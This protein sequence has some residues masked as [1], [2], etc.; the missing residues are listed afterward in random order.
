MIRWPDGSPPPTRQAVLGSP[1]TAWAPRSSGRSGPPSLVTS[2]VPPTCSTTVRSSSST[3]SNGF[4]AEVVAGRVRGGLTRPLGVPS[5]VP[6]R[7][8]PG[9][10]P[11]PVR[12]G[13]DE[14]GV[15][16]PAR[17]TSCSSSRAADWS[18]SEPPSS[19]PAAAASTI[20]SPSPS[21]T[22]GA[23]VG[24]V[25]TI[26]RGRVDVVQ[27]DRRQRRIETVASGRAVE[28][29][30]AG[31]R[32]LGSSASQTGPGGG[33]KPRPRLLEIGSEG[34]RSDAEEPGDWA[35]RTPGRARR[36][37]PVGRARRAGSPTPA[38]R[39]GRTSR[40]R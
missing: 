5:R 24:A 37:A 36:A 9:L 19:S 21:S 22:T 38:C 34:D 25:L 14:V 32:R 33:E 40:A 6:Q 1:S 8:E 16:R 13:D 2:T 18:T 23:A 15:R 29:R 4:E 30:G 11:S 35:R 39:T 20:P 7:V 17:P 26:G 28:P 31:G 10:D 3:S 27:G 12:V